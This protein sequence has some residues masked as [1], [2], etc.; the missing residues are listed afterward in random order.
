MFGMEDETE[1]QK[2]AK[3]RDYLTRKYKLGEEYSK[4]SD[5]SEVRSAQEGANKAQAWALLG[6]AATTFATAKGRARGY[7][8]SD[9]GFWDKVGRSKDDDVA[10]ARERLK[11]RQT[12]VLQADSFADGAFK[13][14][15]D[16]SDLKR[17]DVLRGREDE[18]WNRDSEEY[19][20]KAGMQKAEDDPNS[21]ASV[22]YQG[23][24]KK[25]RPEQ[26]F[27]GKSAT[28]IKSLLDPMKQIYTVDEQ[29]KA[30]TEAAQRYKEGMEASARERS[31][32]RADAAAE[33]AADR[34]ERRR[35][36]EL[37]RE[38][39]RAETAKPKPLTA[40]Q[41]GKADNVRMA[42]TAVEDM[43]TAL[44]AGEDTFKVFGDNNFTEAR[45][46]FQESLGRLQSGGAIGKDEEARFADMA[47]KWNDSPE[48]RQRKLQKLRDE[49]SQRAKGFAGGQANAPSAGPSAAP[50]V[51]SRGSIPEAD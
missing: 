12:G 3:L 44:D 41:Q 13:A 32:T 29:S 50:K 46:R 25:L 20:R 8:R 18:K 17:K 42:A 11:G 6:D 43:A 45:R 34:A 27:T 33:R 24:A 40:E 36:R 2:R 30:K 22:M 47:P 15:G 23:L 10:A 9:G 48:M 39:K 38:D 35:E 4:A 26:D 16:V 37:D 21:P 19:G 28:E 1:E 5:D 51:F 14:E 7:E 31:L 49:L